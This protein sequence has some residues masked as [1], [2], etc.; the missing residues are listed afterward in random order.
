M[1]AGTAAR[2]RRS[3]RAPGRSESSETD[4]RANA[5][6]ANEPLSRAMEAWQVVRP[7]PIETHPLEFTELPLPQPRPGEILVR[8]RCCG[9]CRTN[10]HIAEGDLPPRTPNV[11]PGHQIVGVVEAPG[12]GTSRFRIGDRIGI[13][14]RRHTCGRCRFCARGLENLCSEARFTGWNVDGGYAEYAVVD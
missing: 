6:A 8:V 5:R 2:S 11:V 14:W 13:A 3:S 7:G 9:V 4:L 10:L 12:E 1:S